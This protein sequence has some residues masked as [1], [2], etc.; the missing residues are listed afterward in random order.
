M[1]ENTDEMH[2]SL[3]PA[4]SHT[5]ELKFQCSPYGE[6]FILP[7]IL[8][9]NDFFSLFCFL[10]TFCHKVR[11]TDS[12]FKHIF[13]IKINVRNKQLTSDFEGEGAKKKVF[14]LNLSE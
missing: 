11:S 9:P 2:R 3:I 1:A 13:P 7:C 14:L 4:R 12:P 8:F 5:V 10:F 6:R